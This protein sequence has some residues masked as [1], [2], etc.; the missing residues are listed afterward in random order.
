MWEADSVTSQ[1]SEL[2]LCGPVSR[3]KGLFWAQC[4]K[5]LWAD[6]KVVPGVD[7]KGHQGHQCS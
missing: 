7:G 6:E 2:V 4:K 5:T 3:R 1:G